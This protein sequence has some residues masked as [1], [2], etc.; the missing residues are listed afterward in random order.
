M[1]T[2]FYQIFDPYYAVIKAHNQDETLEVY[3]ECVADVEE[4]DKERFL[5]N[6]EVINEERVKWILSGCTDEETG[7]DLTPE[8]QEETLNRI[9]PD[10]IIMEE[11]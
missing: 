2:Y 6:M 5:D 8:Q 7:K 11:P 3:E 1:N 10:I 9:A 4:D